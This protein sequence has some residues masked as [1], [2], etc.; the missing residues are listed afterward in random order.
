MT[1]TSSMSPP[2]WACAVTS[3]GM[4]AAKVKYAYR[5]VTRGIP[6]VE[7]NYVLGVNTVYS[8]STDIKDIGFFILGYISEWRSNEQV[9][10]L[11]KQ[12]VNYP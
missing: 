6:F 11:P 9:F 1:T 7:G 2:S 8:I 10:D 4:A 12:S 5:A 3:T